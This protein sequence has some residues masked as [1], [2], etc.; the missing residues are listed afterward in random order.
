MFSIKNNILKIIE[1]L[2]KFL[3]ITHAVDNVS[4]PGG[5]GQCERGG[6]EGKGRGVGD[7]LAPKM[8]PLTSIRTNPCH[9][10]HPTPTSPCPRPFFPLISP[11][12]K[13]S[14]FTIIS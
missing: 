5:R 10:K 8:V 2:P 3:M 12:Q 13:Y 7:N 9:T 1:N 11:F 6:G 4:S 14:Y